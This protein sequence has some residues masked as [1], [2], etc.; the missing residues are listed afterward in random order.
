MIIDPIIPASWI[1]SLAVILA[2]LTLVAHLR[3]GRQL[4][5]ARNFLLTTLRLLGVLAVVSL[6]LRFSEEE[7]IVPPSVERSFLVAIDRSASMAE[8]DVEG[9]TRFEHARQIVEN[10]GLLSDEA[11]S[12]VRF[13]LFDDSPQPIDPAML[14]TITPDH[15]HTFFHSSL[16]QLFRTHQ[17]PPPSALLIISDG[18][19]LEGIPPGQTARLAHDRDCVI[20]GLP[21]GAT[22]SARDVSIRIAGFHPYTFRKQMTR[23]AANIRTIGC[24]RETLVI[25][26]LREGKLIDSKR[27]QTGDASFHEIE[28][29]VSEDDPGQY[30]YT[31]KVQPVSNEA[32]TSNNTAINYI[33]VL[34]EKIRVLM[35]EGSPYWD[36]TFLRRSL[37]RNDKLDVD[38]L[39]RFTP[40]R[41]RGVR[42]N[43]ERAN[44]DFTT[45]GKVADFLPYKV[46]ILGK[47]VHEILGED[48]IKAMEEWVDQ[49]GGI[50]IFA[51]GQAWENLPDTGLVPITWSQQSSP[52]RLEISTAALSVPP[53]RLLHQRTATDQ[54]PEIISYQAEGDPKTLAESYVNTTTRNSGVVFRRFGSGQ[55]LSLGV[56][57]LW[58][59]VFN[60]DAEFDNNLYDL[61]WDQLVLWMLSNGGVTPGDDY[62]FQ[63]NTANLATGE[64]ITFT[65]S[66]NGLDPPQTPPTVT[67]TH[68]EE[69]A[70]VLALAPNDNGSAYTATFTPRADGR[71][72]AAV[73]FPNGRK[74]TARF[75]A[76]IEEIERTETTTDPAYLKQL[77]IA[78]GGRLVKAEEIKDLFANIL[79]E[80]NPM[81][82]RTRLNPLWDKTW[83]LFAITFLLAL[84]WF[85]RRRWGLT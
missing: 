51:R 34:N 4:G 5:R 23:L 32:Q 12:L 6:L 7:I 81:N 72:L 79:R 43:P 19:D 63:T 31:F 13:H 82:E 45:P 46:V 62:T 78:S 11:K 39:I 2:A 85:L 30:E 69:Q 27:L 10:A 67:V 52:A 35:L 29:L 40:D 1:I 55:T 58:K 8:D 36:T 71:H 80:A 33:N 47:Q 59:W 49:H 44:M 26:L 18:H 37:A 73:T 50:V 21:V 16:R 14:E 3:S 56:G 20:Y 41:V 61:F 60:K 68:Q 22:G 25:D 64:K 57:D 48:G 65:L 83:V 77:A 42:S 70:A 74:A 28:F 76:F 66:L 24:P 53:F 54:L 15:D 38:A 9:I 75:M 84:E 17:G